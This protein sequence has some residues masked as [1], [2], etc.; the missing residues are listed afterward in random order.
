MSNVNSDHIQE[1]ASS[2]LM[3]KSNF[4]F[5][6][7]WYILNYIYN[8]KTCTLLATNRTIISIFCS[9]IKRRNFSFINIIIEL[10][11]HFLKT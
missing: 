4:Q 1:T 8:V 11:K 2:Y 6:Y 5:N 10:S 9:L 3:V 7:F